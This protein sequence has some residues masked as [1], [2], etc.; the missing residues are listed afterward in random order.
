[1]CTT[2]DLLMDDTRTNSSTPAIA[3]RKCQIAVR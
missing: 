1:M 2:V 3:V